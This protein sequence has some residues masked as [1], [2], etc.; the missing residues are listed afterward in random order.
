L[1]FRKS[2]HSLEGEEAPPGKRQ[3]DPTIAIGSF[4]VRVVE[5]QLEIEKVYNWK[6]CVAG[7]CHFL[8]MR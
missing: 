6:E 7:A 3:D 8:K 4:I 5:V 2:S 1:V